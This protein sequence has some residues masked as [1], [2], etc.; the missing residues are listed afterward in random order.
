MYTTAAIELCSVCNLTSK[1]V[2]TRYLCISS[3]AV[4]ISHCLQ[5]F[6]WQ[7]CT[8]WTSP[9]W[10]Q[11]LVHSFW[12]NRCPRSI[13]SAT[14]D[15][16]TYTW[17]PISVTIYK[18]NAEPTALLTCRMVVELCCC[19]LLHSLMGEVANYH[20]FYVCILLP[21]VLHLLF[22]WWYAHAYQRLSMYRDGTCTTNAAC[23]III[24]TGKYL[25]RNVNDM[26]L[27]M[28]VY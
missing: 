21:T 27:C 1:G 26:N 3:S 28:V 22:S 11:P 9:F 8:P 23:F 18:L 12:W 6:P 25:L 19:I 14:E 2:R 4:L 13:R 17:E 16:W 20:V 10:G 7:G 5:P 15:K 24:Y